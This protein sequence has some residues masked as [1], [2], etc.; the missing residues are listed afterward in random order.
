MITEW[1]AGGQL[2]SKPLWFLYRYTFI[3]VS[4]SSCYWLL[5]RQSLLQNESKYILRTNFT[6]TSRFCGLGSAIVMFFPFCVCVCVWHR[7]IP[8]EMIN[9][10][11]GM[12]LC[13][14]TLTGVWVYARVSM[15]K[16][17]LRISRLRPSGKLERYSSLFGNFCRAK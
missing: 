9:V 13:T 17:Q 16:C 3:L 6:Y 14:C 10:L 8:T 5:D 7:K 15:I 12:K 2:E 11:T 1:R 4:V